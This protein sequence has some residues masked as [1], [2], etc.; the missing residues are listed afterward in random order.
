M[1][2]GGEADRLVASGEV[3][4]EPGDEGV[5]EI[6]T[7]TVQGEWGGEC[8]IGGGASVEIEG[9]NSGRVS[10]HSLDLDGVDE[11]LGE[12]SLLEWGVIKSIDVVPDYYSLLEEFPRNFIMVGNLQPIFSSLYS[13]SSIPAM[14]MVAL[15]GKIKP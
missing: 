7:T 12:G 9:Q 5:D 13:P 6:I 1:R 2:T 3:D 10:D 4:V 8:E 11:G 14:K 15:S